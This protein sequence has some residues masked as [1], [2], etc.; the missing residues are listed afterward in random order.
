MLGIAIINY[1]TFEKTVDC[2]NSIF[3]TVKS[4]YKIYLLD[5]ASPNNSY[6]E[7][8][9]AYLGNENVEL[10]KSEE[11]LGYARGN[12][13]L[14]ERAQSDG[15]DCVL[16]SNNDIVFKDNSVDLLYSQIKK[17]RSLIV[18][19]KILGTDGKQQ[20]SVKAVKP[21]FKEYILFS[22]Y[23]IGNLVS[24]K[25]TKKYAEKMFART[26][27]GVYWASGA[28]FMADLKQFKEIGYF[29]PY[30]FLYFE[31]YIISE[32]AKKRSMEIY[33]YPDAAVMHH[34][35]ASTGGSVNLVTRLANFKSESYMFSN[36]WIISKPKLRFIRLIRCFEV[37]YSFSK[38]KQFKDITVFFK[39]SR[40][41]LKETPRKEK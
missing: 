38:N 26:A 1:N 30:T 32:K 3:E 25:R 10:I 27:S 18:A 17:R 9:K 4:D 2:I 41:I 8:E 21:S 22:N 37:F 16:I 28:C 29:D 34:H 19:P 20:L 23:V 7:L 14:I 36:Y 39:Q 11:N 33:Y 24:K 15:C 35:G 40:K 31:E 5:N 6:K 13:L 12:N